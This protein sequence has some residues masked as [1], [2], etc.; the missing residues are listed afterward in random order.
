MNRWDANMKKMA[1]GIDLLFCVS[2]CACVHACVTSV[3]AFVYPESVRGGRSSIHLRSHWPYFTSIGL[4]H[5][6]YLRHVASFIG[7]LAGRPMEYGR[8]WS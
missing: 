4:R 1:S 2:A 3:H 5:E 7:G 8:C 6:H